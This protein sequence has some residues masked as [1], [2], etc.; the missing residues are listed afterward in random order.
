M[1]R[2]HQ[3]G[4]AGLQFTE[5]VECP[6]VFGAAFELPLIVVMA[7]LAGVLSGNL[8]KRSQRI[9]VFLIFLFAAVATPTTDP[10]T[11]IAM[12]VP[13]VILFEA[14]VL[15]AVVHDKR[16]AKRKAAEQAVEAVGDDVASTI[17][18]IPERLDGDNVAPWGDT[19]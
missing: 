4:C 7:N 18:P 5:I 11:M 14:A 16:K 1:R 13:M 9:G 8:L 12:A 15:F 6:D 17:N 10:F 3:P 19:T 2:N